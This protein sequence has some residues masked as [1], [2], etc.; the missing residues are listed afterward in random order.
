[1]A[2][3]PPRAEL[4]DRMIKAA[5][6]I[7]AEQGLQAL[8]AR[9][10][11]ASVGCAV[12]SIYNV[13]GD[14]DDLILHANAR[15]LALLGEALEAAGGAGGPQERL[16]ALAFAYLDFAVS[17]RRRWKAVFEHVMAENKPV[18]AWYREGQTPL[19]GRIA[20]VLP[21]SMGPDSRAL[22]A[23]TLFSAA[24]GIVSLALDRKLADQFDRLRTERQLRLL[25]EGA[26]RSLSAGRAPPPANP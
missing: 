2:K 4:R 19:L 18:P 9:A 8:Q 16:L 1:M 12:G 25:V 3:A 20:A 22:M 10:V 23:Q 6:A 14:I 11:A 21:G 24:H 15:T 5:E 26:V 17:H 13:F 7:L